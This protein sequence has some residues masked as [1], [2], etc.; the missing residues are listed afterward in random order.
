[1]ISRIKYGIL[2][3]VAGLYSTQSSDSHQS[4]G[5]EESSRPGSLS[6]YVLCYLHYSDREA[7][8][9]EWMV[10]STLPKNW[11]VEFLW[12]DRKIV[13]GIFPRLFLSWYQIFPSVEKCAFFYQIKTSVLSHLHGFQEPFWWTV[14]GIVNKIPRSSNECSHDAGTPFSSFDVTVV[15]ITA[16]CQSAVH[17]GQ[18]LK[19]S[20]SDTRYGSSV[21]LEQLPH[22]TFS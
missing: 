15:P 3:G 22:L 19:T 5:P 1:M 17:V 21:R 12:N 2:K 9:T 8:N 14:A 18:H 11:V 4:S 6:F 13:R 10:N 7:C 20:R 16:E